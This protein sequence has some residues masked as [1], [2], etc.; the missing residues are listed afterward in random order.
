MHNRGPYH[1]PKDL[2]A[3]HYTCSWNA[4]KEM[5]RNLRYD[6]TI[7]HINFGNTFPFATS[8]LMVVLTFCDTK[9]CYGTTSVVK[10]F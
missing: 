6:L 3:E 7:T 9:T 10:T 2:R 1:E 8:F 4:L 5:L